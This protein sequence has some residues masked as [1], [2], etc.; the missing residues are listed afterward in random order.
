MHEIEECSCKS[1]G[2]RVGAR[3]DEQVA[4]APELRACEAFASFWVAG[5]EKVVEEILP[6]GVE[7]DF[8]TLGGLS[9]TVGHVLHA[10]VVDFAEEDLVEAEGLN[11]WVCAELGGVSER[12]MEGTRCLQLSACE[13]RFR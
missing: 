7:T 2:R 5:V 11:C 3:D 6:V 1:C 12:R 13:L 9:F 4:L 10:H 8:G